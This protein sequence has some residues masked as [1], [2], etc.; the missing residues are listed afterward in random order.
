MEKQDSSLELIV[1]SKRFIS[2]VFLDRY[3][4]TY[5]EKILHRGLLCWT[6]ITSVLK[7]TQFLLL[8]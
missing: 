8:L 5:T 4:Y 6:I 3:L 7:I 2:F 1:I